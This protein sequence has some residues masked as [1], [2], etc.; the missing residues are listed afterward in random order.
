[1]RVSISK[2]FSS[3]A[4][5]QVLRCSF[6]IFQVF[7]CF[8]HYSR[9]YTIGCLIFHV[10]QFSHHNTILTVCISNILCFSLYLDILQ[11]QECLFVILHVFQ[12]FSPYL[13]SYHVRF[14]FSFLS[15]FALYS[16]SYNLNFSFSLLVIF[17]AIFKVLQ[18]ALLI[19]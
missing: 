6:P 15:D 9:S 10:F 8:S 19:F 5:I 11:V 3:L 2:F 18:W 4:I 17:L 7:Q 1:V 13:I 14:S 16:R 12:C